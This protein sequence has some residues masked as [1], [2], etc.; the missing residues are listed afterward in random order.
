MADLFGLEAEYRHGRV[1]RDD[2]FC[3]SLLQSFNRMALMQAAGT[4]AGMAVAPHD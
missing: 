4:A 2:A 1:H 3:R